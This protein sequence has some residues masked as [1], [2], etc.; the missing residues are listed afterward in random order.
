DYFLFE[1]LGFSSYEEALVR[2][3]KQDFFDYQLTGL[4]Q[5]GFGSR[6]Q[7]VKEWIRIRMKCKEKQI[8][9]SNNCIIISK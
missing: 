6:M 8:E 9:E 2:V 1:Q 4:F 7:K 5:M 3:R